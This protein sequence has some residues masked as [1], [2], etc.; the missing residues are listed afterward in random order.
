MVAITEA[1]NTISQE[2]V[3]ESPLENELSN[4]LLDL[5]PLAFRYLRTPFTKS[6]IIDH[7]GVVREYMRDFES[8]TTYVDGMIVTLLSERGIVLMPEDD[9][10]L[11][12]Y[13]V[14]KYHLVA[15]NLSEKEEIIY[16]DHESEAQRVFRTVHR[17][18]V[19]LLKNY[20]SDQANLP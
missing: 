20:H 18:R 16:E 3:S 12:T 17:E 5:D 10:R 2:A 8:Y 1:P 11:S 19:D 6:E 13:Q 14:K 7:E 4:K 15:T 9:G